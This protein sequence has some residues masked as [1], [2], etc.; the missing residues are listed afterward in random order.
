MIVI[1]SSQFL[2]IEIQN[3][4]GKLPPS[5]SFLKNKRLYDF[6]INLL[7]KNWP[8]EK[9]FLTL[10]LNYELEM[11]DHERL[12]KLGAEVCFC[13]SELSLGEHIA[14]F[15]TK[16]N[17]KN[18]KIL[19][20]DTLFNE[21]PFEEDAVVIGTPHE[22]ANWDKV[23]SGNTNLVWS[24]YFSFSNPNNLLNNLK[25]NNYSFE[26]AISAYGNIHKLK[27]IENSKWYDFGHLEE[28]H[29]A[30]EKFTT[31]RAFNNLQ[32]NK[33]EVKKTSTKKT[34][35]FDEFNWFQ[36]APHHFQK[37]L[38]NVYDYNESEDKASY[39]MSY[40]SGFSLSELM[41]FSNLSETKWKNILQELSIVLDM[42]EV[43][44]PSNSNEL[45][46]SFMDSIHKKNEQRIKQIVQS[47]FVSEDKTL[48]LDGEILG[49][50]NQIV[51]DLTKKI[52]DY[53]SIPAFCHGDLCFSN[54]IYLSRG[55]ILKLIDP[56]GINR[57]TKNIVGDKRYD[58][59]K[60][61]HSLI[62]GYDRI[63]LGDISFY[64]NGH[65]FKETT[66]IPINKNQE[67]LKRISN[68]LNLKNIL[69]R[70]DVVAITALLFI[71][72]IPLHAESEKRQVSL[73][74]NGLKIYK[75]LKEDMKEA[76]K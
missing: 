32:I 29:K 69:L 34:K 62:W 43:N 51:S 28:L 64:R 70:E 13:S 14:N 7:K 54:I 35:I 38:P 44:V 10:P 52:K 45:A 76:N 42:Q 26:R 20:G 3:E 58:L 36:K 46:K 4:I 57:N 72:M 55:N 60:I 49:N 59:A 2:R 11:L 73:F 50:I 56:R 17:P 16:K 1:P 19:H 6:Q 53:S 5:L 68:E 9:I 22:I 39:K 15:I 24:G 37:F 61:A 48:I 33:Y 71:S 63:L 23:S 74:G 18:L 21:L 12:T 41:L 8:N 67:L 40:I 30:R 31:E 47:S 27:F 75:L 66:K 25:K 65:E